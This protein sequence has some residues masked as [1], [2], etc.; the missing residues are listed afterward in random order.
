IER[1]AVGVSDTVQFWITPTRHWKVR[2]YAVNC[3][4]HAWDLGD[5]G[6]MRESPVQFALDH[7]S[8]HYGDILKSSTVLNF[9]EGPEETNV[10]R[11]LSEN[12]LVGGLQEVEWDGKLFSFWAPNGALY[13]KRTDAE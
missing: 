13:L 8:K 11:V 2:T 1:I 4:V 7:I 6:A 12:G 3:D 10:Q 9:G 5:L